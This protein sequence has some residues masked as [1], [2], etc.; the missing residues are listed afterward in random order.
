VQ[1]PLV[2]VFVVQRQQAVAGRSPEREI[3]H[4]VVVHAGLLRLLSRGVGGIRVPRR[5]RI[6]Q[7]DSIPPGIKHAG[8]V[9]GWD[10]Q[11]FGHGHRHGTETD[12]PSRR[13]GHRS[14]R[15]WHQSCQQGEQADTQ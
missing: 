14:R 13:S 11:R 1:H 8:G 4:A 6:S 15:D 3:R 9:A 2:G 5:L 10:G 12:G 7:P